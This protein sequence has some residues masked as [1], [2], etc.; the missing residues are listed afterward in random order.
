[1]FITRLAFAAFTLFLAGAGHAQQEL[2]FARH[3]QL[4]VEGLRAASALAYT[5]DGTLLVCAA[6]EILRVDE[7]G[8]LLG[9]FAADIELH[10]PAGIAVHPDGRVLIADTGAHRLLLF[11]ADGKLLHTLGGPGAEPGRFHEPRGVAFDA[12]GEHIA[13]CDRGNRRV[14]VLDLE[15]RPILTLQGDPLLGPVACAFADTGELLVADRDAH[16]VR[17]FAADGAPLR[18]IGAWGAH[19]GLLASPSGLAVMGE[20]VLVAERE[21]HRVQ[22]FDLAGNLVGG[23][24]E[25]ALRP[26]EG[27]GK[28]HY[29]AAIAVRR[30]G[31][32]VALAEPLDDRVQIFADE[33]TREPNPLPPM[34]GSPAPPAHYGSEPTAGG[35]L[36]VIAEPETR[37]VLVL[38]DSDRA[39]RLIARVGRAGTLP[40]R[41][42]APH[43]LF[44]DESRARLVVTDPVLRRLSIFHLRG[45]PQDAVRFD[46]LYDRFVKALDFERLFSLSEDSLGVVAPPEPGAV[47]ANAAGELFV[48]DMRN[49]CIWVLSPELAVV[50]R[51]GGPGRLRGP[52]GL[53]LAPDGSELY[54]TESIGARVQ[55][56]ELD[57]DGVRVLEG[58]DFVEPHGIVVAADGRVFVSDAGT[59]RVVAFSAEGE[60]VASYGVRGIGPGGLAQPRGLTI[61]GQGRVVVLDHANHRGIRLDRDLQFAEAF[62]SRLYTRPTMAA[63]DER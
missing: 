49:D 19:P 16:Q 24:G 15:G 37:S 55:A 5:Q 30:D 40:G 61:D 52:A 59:H 46:P 12:A 42:L 29:P 38:D 60:L 57:G 41:F 17:V 47:T 53:A 8:E 1:M 4:E 21:N 45:H 50:R 28:L 6:G 54:V 3:P 35:A 25:H 34:P 63:E 14:Q 48:A 13:V 11:A 26:G 58:A 23:F 7:T 31:A 43:G 33:P 20:L 27:D 51:I 10:F 9:A 32:R 22:A 56:F 2:E 36:L 39:P 44:L 18:T 62:G